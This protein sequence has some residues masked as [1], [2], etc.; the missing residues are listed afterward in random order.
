MTEPF[1]KETIEG[2][3]ASP[4]YLLSKYFYNAEGDRLFQKIMTLDEYYLTR[5]EFEIIESH[6]EGLLEVFK[7]RGS[8]FD[9]IEFGAGDGEKTKIM[10]RHF[11]AQG[12]QFRYIP[13]DISGSVLKELEVSLK[14]EIPDLIVEPLK[15]EYFEALKKLKTDY[16][17][18]KVVLF[19]GSNIGNFLADKAINFLKT[20]Q[21]GLNKGDMVCIGFD[22]KKDPR[23]IEDAYNDSKGVTRDFNLNLLKRINTELGGNFDLSAFLHHPVYDPNSGIARSY[24]VSTRDQV[25]TICQEEIKIDQ[26]EPIHTEISRKFSIK[27][28]EEMASQAGFTPVKNFF[29]QKAYFVD[30]VW[31]CR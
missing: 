3:K 8:G 5:C 13:I 20:L 4:K 31:E 11:L 26:W 30:A 23:V 24:L 21:Q 12:M 7:N 14:L 28:I 1:R 22:L 9:L 29:D 10:L 27:E 2:L 16:T 18:K 19:M 15:N 17:R 6:K 25:V